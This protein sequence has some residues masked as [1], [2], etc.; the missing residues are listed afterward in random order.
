MLK[1]YDS[2]TEALTRAAPSVLPT[3]A[4]LTFAAVLFFYFWSSA[5]TKIGMGLTGIFMPTD[6]AY[7]QIFPK[8]VEDLGYDFSKLGVFHW[9][10]AVA[11]TLAELFLPILIVLGLFTRL[12]ALGM[13]GFIVVQSITDIFGH[14]IMGDDLGSWFDM[15]SGALILDQRTLW[16]T[17]LL[18]LV[19]LGAGPLSLD[20]LLAR[21]R[22][23][24]ASLQ[25]S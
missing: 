24:S 5:Q 23:L 9:A 6:G 18:T 16:V 8:T 3:I 20:R 22:A 13:I 4:R 25:Q 11:G 12:A 7:V 15:A 2:I 1:F 21:S 19:F 14:G 17:L 10:V